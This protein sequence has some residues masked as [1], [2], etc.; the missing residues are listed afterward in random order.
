MVLG[1]GDWFNPFPFRVSPVIMTLL[2][3]IIMLAGREVG[4]VSV[5]VAPDAKV[6]VVL[7]LLM[8]HVEST[9]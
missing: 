3:F 6:I 9:V 1:E 4:A 2:L 7:A 8:F 5:S